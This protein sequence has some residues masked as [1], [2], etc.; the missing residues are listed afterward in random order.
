M[1][2]ILSMKK[3][4]ALEIKYTAENDNYVRD[5]ISTFCLPI[6]EIN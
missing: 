5:Y 6:Y 1:E 4:Q 2:E 3:P